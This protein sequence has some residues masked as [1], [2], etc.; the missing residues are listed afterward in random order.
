[1]GVGEA[2]A[3]RSA[4][5]AAGN[6]LQTRSLSLSLS[7]SLSVLSIYV[8]D[9]QIVGVDW[10][11]SQA[12]G[13][14][15]LVVEEQN[16]GAARAIIFGPLE[17]QP[18][19]WKTGLGPRASGLGPTDPQVDLPRPEDRG[20][21]PVLDSCPECGS[22]RFVAVP[23][24]RIFLLLAAV[25]IG[26]GAAV[27]QTALALTALIAVAAGALMMPSSRCTNCL[28]RFTPP[29]QE[30]CGEAPLPGERDTIEEQCPRCASREVY[31]IDYRR[32]KAIPLLFNAS[33]FLA[34]P[35]WLLSPKRRCDSCGLKLW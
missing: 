26:I 1:M 20:P 24:L 23:R 30:D 4:L 21:R 25:F 28:H 3:A 17:S 27:G 33:I 5:D 14:I 18:E 6:R 2:E 16:L 32:V 11:M 19:E 12:V 34:L 22:T 13:G 15:K 8:V 29:E 9:D 10:A 7:L 31:Q 35:W